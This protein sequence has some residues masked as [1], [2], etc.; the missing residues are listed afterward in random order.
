MLGSQCASL[1]TC[2]SIWV[3][4]KVLREREKCTCRLHFQIIIKRVNNHDSVNEKEVRW[5]QSLFEPILSRPKKKKKSIENSEDLRHSQKVLYSILLYYFH[6]IWLEFFQTAT[7]LMFEHVAKNIYKIIRNKKITWST[8][9]VKNENQI[10][11]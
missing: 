8:K 6:P 4:C 2:S 10:T 9:E 3:N 1:Q 11:P 5:S 7:E